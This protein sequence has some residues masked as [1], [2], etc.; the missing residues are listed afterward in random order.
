MREMSHENVCMFVGACIDPPNIYIVMQHCTK[1]TL[2]D[3]IGQDEIGLDSLFKLSLISD[4]THVS[5]ATIFSI[6]SLMQFVC[7][8]Q[9][10]IVI[11]SVRL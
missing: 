5:S 10:K 8:D 4:L 9:M 3:I 6:S 7:I 11:F 1:G 2:M